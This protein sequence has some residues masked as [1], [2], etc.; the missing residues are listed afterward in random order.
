MK[1]RAVRFVP[2]SKLG[3]STPP[4]WKERYVALIEEYGNYAQTAKMVGVSGKTALRER[5]RDPEFD[6]ACQEAR[7]IFADALETKM[8][9]S[10]QESG[11]PAGFIVRLKAL[12]PAEYI[13]KHAI[14][15]L[16][17]T[18]NLNEL[19]VPD[20]TA[21]LRAMLGATTTATQQALTTGATP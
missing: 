9:A 3:P 8:I 20:A 10:A 16:T 13:E 17:L 1:P 12:R 19:P 15:S 14:T 2:S 5:D 4:D 18:A 7:Q 6:D 21:L 11:N